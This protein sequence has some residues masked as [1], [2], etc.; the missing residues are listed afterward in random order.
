MPYNT[1][2]KYYEGIQTKKDIS[3]HHKIP[4]RT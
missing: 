4:E 3:V 2:R 1:A